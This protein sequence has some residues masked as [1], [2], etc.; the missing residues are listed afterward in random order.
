MTPFERATA[1]LNA[2]S[3]HYIN[4]VLRCMGDYASGAA[5]LKLSLSPDC[6]GDWHCVSDV[7]PNTVREII[8]SHAGRT[9]AQMTVNRT[10]EDGRLV[11]TIQY[12]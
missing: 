7:D 1:N 5:C 3:Q 8:M 9:P 12:E 6:M 4:T 2:S 10:G 11:T